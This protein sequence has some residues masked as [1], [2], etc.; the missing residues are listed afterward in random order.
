MIQV[1]KTT[2]YL[3]ISIF[4]K[5]K[6]KVR[7][8]KYASSNKLIFVNTDGSANCP[9]PRKL[10]K[11]LNI[12]FT[13]ENSTVKIHLPAN[14]FKN[15]KLIIKNNCKC[16]I[17]QNTEKILFGFNNFTLEMCDNSQVKIGKNFYCGQLSAFVDTDSSLII[18]D[19]C[20][21][22]VGINI[23][24]GDGT[25]H[26][27]IDLTTNTLKNTSGNIVIGNHV[28]GG[29]GS[30]FLKNAKVSDNSIVGA[31]SVVSKRF[32]KENI[33]I[34]GNPAKQITENIDWKAY[35]SWHR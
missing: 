21:F 15:C 9:P 17:G 32:E 30:V 26:Q 12:N 22:S 28:W 7:Y 33:A 29:L 18:G 5:L 1:K 11:G 31:Y 23:R 10:I 14:R 24:S 27:I 19:D 35:E 25:N 6:I 16:E 13:G 2:K 4:K 34:G 20:M 8:A 3:I